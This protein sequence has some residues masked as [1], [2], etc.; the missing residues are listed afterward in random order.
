MI[1]TT[2]GELATPADGSI[3]PHEH[4]HTDLLP[5]SEG[6]DR[7]VS[8][9]VIHD[10]VLPKLVR[11]KAAGASVLMECT[12]PCVGQNVEAVH[13][14]CQ[15]AGLAAVVPTGLYKEA[16]QPPWAL[17]ASVSD[18][19]D[20]MTRHLVDGMDGTD[21]RAGFIKLAV[22][23]EGVTP[24]E[25]KVLEAGV[26][27]SMATGAP[28]ACHS[29]VGANALHQ[30][31]MIEDLGGDPSRYIQVHAHAESN[32]DTHLEILRRGAWI[33]YDGIGGGEPDSFFI[34][35]T[36]KVFDAGL[37]GR[38]LLSQDV[39]GYLVDREPHT[40][41][42]QFAYL[43]ET[44]APSLTK[45]GFGAKEIDGLI[46]LNPADAFSIRSVAP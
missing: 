6:G 46:R 36:R 45:Y 43:I 26:R 41:D 3:L 40:D 32:F 28:I 20:W 19:A 23:D 37:G 2:S 31:G 44:F 34:D 21:R 4:I 14:A 16:F 17:D 11:A 13:S 42:R 1:R 7:K 29:P 12:P 9:D 5:L 15:A 39:C 18:L 8:A 27:A 10:A 30:I 25:D 33:E 22:T 24:Q 38:I 35:L